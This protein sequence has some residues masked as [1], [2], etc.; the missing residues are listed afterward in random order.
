MLPVPDG[1]GKREKGGEESFK[2][3]KKGKENR[4]VP[5][6][7]FHSTPNYLDNTHIEKKRGK[8]GGK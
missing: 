6:K 3:K 7:A 8:G 1:E 2:K 5:Y 4:P